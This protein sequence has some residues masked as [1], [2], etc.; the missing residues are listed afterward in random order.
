MFF[1]AFLKVLFI[2]SLEQAAIK[3]TLGR[4]EGRLKIQ[5]SGLVWRAHLVLL[6]GLRRGPQ[7]SMECCIAPHAKRAKQQ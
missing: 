2:R 3:K 7:A 6:L 5:R 4:C 1:L